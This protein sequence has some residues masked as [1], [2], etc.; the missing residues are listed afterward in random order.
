[1]TGVAVIDVLVVDDHALMRAGLQG[2]IDGAED[3]RVVGMAGD[4]AEALDLI[5]RSSPHVV[6]MDL[7]MPGMDGVTA[8]GRIS[9]EHPDTAVLVLT[10]FSD[11]ARVL[12]A[13][14]AGAVGYVLKDTDPADLL[15]AIRAV[16]RGQSPLDPRVARTVLHGRRVAAPAPAV[17]LTE[18]EH[19]VLA[20]VGR[21]LAN[22]Q[23]AR[24][25]GIREATVKAHLTSVFQRIGVRDR[26]SAALWAQKNL[27][28]PRV[29]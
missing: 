9:E 12:Q 14:D 8:T 27:P 15:D 24:A 25:L 29:R 26:T 11:Q 18:R 2:L 28:R 19:E 13:L 4:G 16:A 10:S 6:L 5:P 7:S 23:I 20:L 22:K 3:M 1:M 21:G 17:E